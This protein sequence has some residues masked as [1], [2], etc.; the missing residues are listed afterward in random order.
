MFKAMKID[1]AIVNSLIST[2][3]APNEKTNPAIRIRR[4]SDK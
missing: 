1:K 3:F 2:S 4:I